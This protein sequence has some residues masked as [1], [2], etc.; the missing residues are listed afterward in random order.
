MKVVIHQIQQQHWSLVRF[1][2]LVLLLAAESPAVVAPPPPQT[3]KPE[4]DDKC[5]N[6]IVPYPFGIVKG[7]YKNKDFKL[8]CAYTDRY[9]IED[10]GDDENKKERLWLGGFEILNISVETG[11][12]VTNVFR[13]F[14]CY[15]STEGRLMASDH[16]VDLRGTPFTLSPEKNKFI[17]I[18]CDTAAFMVDGE[19]TR[20]TNG[21]MS[22]CYDRVNLTDTEDGG[23]SG[24]GCC[25]TEIPKGV[26]YLNTTVHTFDNFSYVKDFNP[27]GFAFLA[28][29][30]WYGFTNIDP[31][32]MYSVDTYMSPAVLDWVVGE[33]TC[34]SF[35][36]HSNKSYYACGENTKCNNSYNGPGYICSCKSGYE[37]NPYLPQ[38]CQDSPPFSRSSILSFILASTH[39]VLGRDHRTVFFTHHNVIKSS[40]Q[41]MNRRNSLRAQRLVYFHIEIDGM[42]TD[43]LLG[44]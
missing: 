24:V 2:F 3:V 29:Q 18:G 25:R 38:G 30:D 11:T 44:R 34:E 42:M 17:A 19:G 23:C 1:V 33:D 43:G 4:C 32:D 22:L 39:H 15:N 28:D 10:G 14:D 36:L 41:V 31:T 8:R 13:A 35:H 20:F 26:K 7:C 5:G 21:C 27:C 12:A 6:E 16:T 40:K 37:G 9:G